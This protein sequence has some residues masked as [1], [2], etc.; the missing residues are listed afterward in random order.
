MSSSIPLLPTQKPEVD[1]FRFR[2]E[3][4]ARSQPEGED[5]EDE[6]YEE[7]TLED[8]DNFSPDSK[9]SWWSWKRL[10]MPSKMVLLL[11][12]VCL[13]FVLGAAGT[14]HVVTK[15]RLLAHPPPLYFDPDK[16]AVIIEKRNL[17]T[18][19]TVLSTFIARTPP[20]WPFQ[21]WHGKENE[22]ALRNSHILKDYIATGKLTL[23][24]LPNEDAVYDG[25]SLSRFLTLPD[26]WEALAPAKHIFFFQADTVICAR[27]NATVNDFLGLDVYPESGYDWVGAQWWF[28]FV[29][30][31]FVAQAWSCGLNVSLPSSRGYPQAPYGGNG[32]FCIRRRE[33]MLNVTRQFGQEWDGENEDMWF[34]DR[35]QRT[36]NQFPAQ[37]IAMSFAF[38][39]PPAGS[40]DLDFVYEPYGVHIGNGGSPCDLFPR[41]LADVPSSQRRSRSKNQEAASMV[42]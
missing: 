19:L 41:F 10:M 4:D 24:Q 8:Y 33:A 37:D 31:Y 22:F 39:A 16:V 26:F 12:P 25:R 29:S 6:P 34:A 23:V 21:I 2:H 42:S 3:V 40:E 14:T 17:P 36:S 32:G 5:E 1:S 38:E 9:P 28:R 35:L 30:F 15:S 13:L 7:D 27:S 11:V 18:L 20:E